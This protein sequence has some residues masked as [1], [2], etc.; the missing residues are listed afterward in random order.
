MFITDFTLHYI[1]LVNFVY[2]EVN[3]AKRTE[4]RGILFISLL[5]GRSCTYLDVKA[6]IEL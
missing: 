1:T 6:N 3:C 4:I 5:K 2:G